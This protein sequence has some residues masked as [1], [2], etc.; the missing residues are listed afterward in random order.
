MVH[1]HQVSIKSE[2]WPS[3]LNTRHI[4]KKK[5]AQPTLLKKSTIPLLAT[6]SNLGEF[7]VPKVVRLKLT[8]LQTAAKKKIP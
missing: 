5:K 8:V 3:Q 7:I 6:E 2:L 1:L 4:N